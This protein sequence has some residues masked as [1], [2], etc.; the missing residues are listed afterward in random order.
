MM[1]KYRK[2]YREQMDQVRLSDEADQAILEDILKSDI[3]KDG[4]RSHGCGGVC[5]GFLYYRIC[6]R[7]NPQ[8]DH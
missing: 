7:Y 8:N 1:D 3:Q 2:R 4:K 6:R 5:N